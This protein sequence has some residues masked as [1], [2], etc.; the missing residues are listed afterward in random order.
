[1]S[2]SGLLENKY[3]FDSKSFFKDDYTYKS[4]QI[5]KDLEMKYTPAEI[6]NI[7]RTGKD[8]NSI[9]NNFS[10]TASLRPLK[11]KPIYLK[12]TSHLILIYYIN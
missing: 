7:I 1:M 11:K 6:I 5:K 10:I 8:F 12:K 9:K 2:E 3:V 4:H